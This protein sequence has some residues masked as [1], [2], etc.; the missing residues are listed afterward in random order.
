VPRLCGAFGSLGKQRRP[1]G[2]SDAARCPQPAAEILGLLKSE[3]ETG[4]VP[5]KTKL[6][7]WLQGKFMWMMPR[8]TTASYADEQGW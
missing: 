5:G 4:D 6:V 8:T 2:G 3:L 7:Y 1:S